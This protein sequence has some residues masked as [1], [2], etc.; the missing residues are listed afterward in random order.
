MNSFL[1]RSSPLIERE[2]GR[3]GMRFDQAGA[4]T[5]SMPRKSLT[6]GEWRSPR[7]PR[8]E[9]ATYCDVILSDGSSRA[10]FYS[11]LRCYY[12]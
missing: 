2:L 10:H 9:S 6:S 1:V 8:H 7:R 4:R 5:P 12:T 3:L 11:E